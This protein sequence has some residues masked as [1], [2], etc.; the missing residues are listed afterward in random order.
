MIVKEQIHTFF[1]Q[2]AL[3]EA[4]KSL[5]S[6]DVPIGTVIVFEEKI[7]GRGYNQVEKLKDPLAHAEM[8]AL[9]KAVKKIGYK[10]LLDC[11]MYVTLEPCSMC[12]GALVLARV[13]RLFIG[14]LDKKTGAALSLYQ[15]PKD[16]RLNHRIEIHKGILEQECSQIIKTFF[17]ELR[18]RKKNER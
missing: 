13:K 10:H 9:R 15:I 12:S 16:E 1:M 6:G 2:K 17:K 7:I 11:D 18:N 14:A 5:E 3:K 4:E 8:I